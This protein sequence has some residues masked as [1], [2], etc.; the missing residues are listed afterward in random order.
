[1]KISHISKHP[2]A[3]PIIANWIVDE[4][5]D[6]APGVNFK[7]ITTSLKREIIENKIPKTFIA[8]EKDRYLGTASIFENDMSTRP[9][10]TP[11]LAAVYV[12]SK[13]RNKGVGSE[14]VKFVMNEAKSLDLKK[15][16]LWT[17]NKMNFYQ[18]LD[19]KFFERTNF[20]NKDVTIMIYEF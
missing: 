8:F 18:N 5:G 12:D 17:A 3:I 20:L 19:W 1:M 11:W 9:E 14:L 4:W 7:N 2:N 6:T 15:L 16:Y 13:Y 10:L